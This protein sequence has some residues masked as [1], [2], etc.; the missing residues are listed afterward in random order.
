MASCGSFMA[1]NDDI[2]KEA[3]AFSRKQVLFSFAWWNRR[4]RYEKVPWSKW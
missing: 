1:G 4:Y 2:F 3:G